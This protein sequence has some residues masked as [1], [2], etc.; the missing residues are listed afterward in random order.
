MNKNLYIITQATSIYNDYLPYLFKSLSNIGLSNIWDLHLIVMSDKEPDF[1]F[2][3]NKIDKK[4]YYHIVD[5]PYCFNLYLRPN[6]IYDFFKENN[7]DVNNDYF[8]FV[9]VDTIFRNGNYYKKIEHDLLTN[10]MIFSISPWFNHDYTTE[11]DVCKNKYNE[12][13]IVKIEPKDYLQLSFFAGQINAFNKFFEDYKN[14][15]IKLISNWEEKKIPPM[16]DQ[17]IITYLVWK[18][19]YKN[20]YIKDNYI[21]NI[22]QDL[23]LKNIKKK[24]INVST[25]NNTFNINDYPNIFLIQKFNTYIKESI[26]ISR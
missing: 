9:D 16:N 24:F 8:L 3:P 22:Y 6:I 2:V 7:F 17:S 1:K 12:I 13:C 21:I 20:I 26:R 23:E 15:Q 5:F 19:K 10:K 18:N 4:I 14:L 11:N 25:C